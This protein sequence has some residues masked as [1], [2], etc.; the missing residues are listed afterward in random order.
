MMIYY[1]KCNCKY[2]YSPYILNGECR[3]CYGKNPI[4]DNKINNLFYN[5]K[6]YIIL[7]TINNIITNKH[8]NND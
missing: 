4:Q 7:N 6:Y 1:N 2:G 3:F 5:N 8:N